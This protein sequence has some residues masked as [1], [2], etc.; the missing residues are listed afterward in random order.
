QRTLHARDVNGATTP[1]RTVQLDGELGRGGIAKTLDQL[2]ELRFADRGC[3][4]AASG[5]WQ[6]ASRIPITPEPPLHRGFPKRKP[7]RQ[8]CIPAFSGPVRGQHTLA[9]RYRVSCAHEPHQIKIR[10][11]AQ[12]R[13]TQLSSG[14][15]HIDA[16]K[17]PDRFDP[18]AMLWRSRFFD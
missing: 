16:H 6:H 7:F 9:K 2:P 13:S 3:V 18:K 4:P 14:V 1:P 8:T 5:T 12:Q 11:R 10:S 17:S 15:K